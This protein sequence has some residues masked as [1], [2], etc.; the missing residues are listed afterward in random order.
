MDGGDAP[1]PAA[2]AVGHAHADSHHAS[3]V[4]EIKKAARTHASSTVTS[5]RNSVIFDHGNEGGNSEFKFSAP[6]VDIQHYFVS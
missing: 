5:G 3:P 1:A 4:A 6:S 2:A